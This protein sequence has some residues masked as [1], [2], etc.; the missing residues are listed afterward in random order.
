M[1]KVL[2]FRD[3]QAQKYGSLRWLFQRPP[4]K[5]IKVTESELLHNSLFLVN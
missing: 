2:N 3:K 4:R 1:S 5:I